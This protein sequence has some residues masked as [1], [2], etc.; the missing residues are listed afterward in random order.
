MQ[1]EPSLPN[2]PRPNPRAWDATVDPQSSGSYGRAGGEP[3]FLPRTTLVQDRSALHAPGRFPTHLPNGRA[4]SSSMCTITDGKPL[5]G[6][7]KTSSI[8]KCCEEAAVSKDGK[9][10]ARAA[11]ASFV[12][13]CAS[14]A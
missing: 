4:P 13:K 6:A 5:A 9:P 11:K 2:H 10:L 12:K 8:K 1:V 14:G 3:Y 7:A